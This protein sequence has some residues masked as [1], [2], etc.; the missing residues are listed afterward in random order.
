[1]SAPPLPTRCFCRGCVDTNAPTVCSVCGQEVRLG[2]RDGIKSWLHREPVEHLTILGHRYTQAA[3]DALELELDKP[4]ERFVPTKTGFPLLFEIE[5][6]TTREHT[7]AKMA[8]AAREAAELEEEIETAPIPAPEVRSTPIEIGDPR[9]PG[10]AKTIINLARKN[11]WTAWAT[12][13]R[14][15]RVHST[16]GALLEISDNVL[17]RLRLDGSERR[18]VGYWITKNDKP[19]FE[20]AWILRADLENRKYT[21]VSANSDEL[22][23]WIKG[24]DA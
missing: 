19:A 2:W 1:M 7:I 20:F 11:G 17:V 22:K 23:A 24:E 5:T 10:G 21:T 13:A 18:A 6:Y 9:L 8:K 16:T 3:H 4:R 14:G 12:Y 15:P